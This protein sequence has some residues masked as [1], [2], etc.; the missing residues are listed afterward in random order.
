MS[1]SPEVSPN[2]NDANKAGVN[3]T[4]KASN[5]N[6]Q[7]KVFQKSPKAI[8]REEARKNTLNSPTKKVGDANGE[9]NKKDD[10]DD[11]NGKMANGRNGG[12]ANSPTKRP[13]KVN[14]GNKN[15]E[16][17]SPQRKITPPKTQESPSPTRKKVTIAKPQESPSPTRKTTPKVIQNNSPTRKN[18]QRD[19]PSPPRK[20]IKSPLPSPKVDRKSFLTSESSPT[21]LLAK[22]P[23]NATL[24]PGRPLPSTNVITNQ[25]VASSQDAV[26]EGTKTSD[27]DKVDDKAKEKG[28]SSE[29]NAVYDRLLTLCKRGD[30]LAVETLL[31]HL[32]G[33]QIPPDL[34]DDVSILFFMQV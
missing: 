6:G 21:K 23:N 32:D 12:P 9:K 20:K 13:P 8:K 29:A 2:N 33:L 17:N 22:A 26:K 27:G 18:P 4:K 30:W 14:E 31:N 7:E 34:V 3:N 24:A 10:N 19:S 28:T 16:K 1:N 5:V 25:P 11:K 15:G